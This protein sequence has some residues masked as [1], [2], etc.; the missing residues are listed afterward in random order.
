MLW[1][2]KQQQKHGEQ[3]CLYIVSMMC[4]RSLILK[5][6]R[7]AG[8]TIYSVYN[9]GLLPAHHLGT[10]DDDDLSRMWLKGWLPASTALHHCSPQSDIT[11]G[12]M[13]LN[14]LQAAAQQLKG[15]VH[16]CPSRYPLDNYAKQATTQL[17]HY[18]RFPAHRSTPGPE[19][20]CQ[21]SIPPS[22]SLFQWSVLP[23]QPAGSLGSMSVSQ[24]RIPFMQT[25]CHKMLCSGES[26]IKKVT[27]QHQLIIRRKQLPL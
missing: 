14:G 25:T 19:R 23:H 6:T 16:K 10:G 5:L 17:Q 3:R 9:S 12:G 22:Y 7:S 15:A 4:N 1:N 20:A 13:G 21:A 11:A 18:N 8:D 2:Y 26:L 27:G 24:S